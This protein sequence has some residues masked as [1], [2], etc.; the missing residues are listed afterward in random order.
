MHFEDYKLASQKHLQTSLAILDSIIEHQKEKK[1]KIIV[2]PYLEASLHNVYYLSGYTIECI[3]NY[4]IFKHYNWKKSS[5]KEVDHNFSKKC[6][7]SFYQNER[8][9]DGGTYPYFI[10]QHNYLRNL[11]ILKKVYSNSRLPMLDRSV[12]INNDAKQLFTHWNV[13]IRYHQ[14][15]TKYNKVALTIQSVTSFVELTKEFHNGL[16]ALVG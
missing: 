8:R 4:S 3:V 1:S 7:L 9:E 16:I 2:N 11:D 10:N 6:G 14:P 15:T 5:V 12:G 13:E